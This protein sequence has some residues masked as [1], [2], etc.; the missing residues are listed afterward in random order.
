M[1]IILGNTYKVLQNS[2]KGNAM[3][4]HT[5]KWQPQINF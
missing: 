4:I 5:G 1:E 3:R 2:L